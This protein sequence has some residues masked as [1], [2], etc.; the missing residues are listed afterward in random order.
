M[1]DSIWYGLEVEIATYLQNNSFPSENFF[2]S[3]EPDYANTNL[4]KPLIELTWAGSRGNDVNNDELRSDRD[5]VTAI[6]IFLE[7]LNTTYA[8]GSKQTQQIQSNLHNMLKTDLKDWMHECDPENYYY[9][10]ITNWGDYVSE[11]PVTK[12]ISSEIIRKGIAIT[13][14]F[15]TKRSFTDG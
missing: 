7:T 14:E 6:T 10:S 8:A 15:H 13:I 1:V 2:I 12:E 5:P 4:V 11:I 9:S 3:V